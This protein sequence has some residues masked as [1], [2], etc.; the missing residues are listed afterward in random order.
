MTDDS[1]REV[2]IDAQE[3]M[4]AARAALADGGHDAF[5]DSVVGLI[6]HDCLAHHRPPRELSP[7]EL[8]LIRL[9]V[10]VGYALDQAIAD[11]FD[12]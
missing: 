11:S 3:V 8:D 9:A 1:S 10:T 2:I 12:D 5:L 4:D 6:R 7:K